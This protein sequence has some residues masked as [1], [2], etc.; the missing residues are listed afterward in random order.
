MR[1]AP[2]GRRALSVGIGILI[3]VDWPTAMMSVVPPIITGVMG[4]RLALRKSHRDE[5]G[6]QR[7]EAAD[8]VLPGLIELRDLIRGRGSPATATA[9]VWSRTVV[10]TFDALESMQ[11]RFPDG[12]RHMGRSVRGA[13]GEF[14]GGVASSDLVRYG[15]ELHLAPYCGKWAAYGEDYLSYT[16]RSLREWRDEPRSGRRHVPELLQFDSWLHRSGRMDGE[17]CGCRWPDG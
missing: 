3:A 5:F 13:V 9:A 16:I 17:P 7:R 1:R 10:T 11:H 14:A 6:S 12:W 2:S 4:Y 15:T 8:T